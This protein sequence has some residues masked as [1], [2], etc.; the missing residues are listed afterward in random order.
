MLSY[1]PEE[2][3]SNLHYQASKTFSGRRAAVGSIEKMKA[4][5]TVESADSIFPADFLALAVIPARIGYRDFV[6]MAAQ[7]RQ[8]GGYLGFKTETVGTQADILDN[9]SL[10]HLV[11]DFHIGQVEIGKHV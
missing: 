5:D 3:T 4:Y 10:E 9:R 11:T 2:V 1:L 8:L 7:A 6:D